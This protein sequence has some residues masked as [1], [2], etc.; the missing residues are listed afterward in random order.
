MSESLSNC[1]CACAAAVRTRS[2][3]SD[4]VFDGDLLRFDDVIGAPMSVISNGHDQNS[5]YVTTSTGALTDS[6]TMI[7]FVPKVCA[8][9]RTGSNTQLQ[10]LVVR[11]HGRTPSRT[12]RRDAVVLPVPVAAPSF[13]V[14]ALSFTAS[15]L[16]MDLCYSAPL[17][18]Q[19]Q[20]F[21]RVCDSRCV[22]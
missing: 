22:L 10:L 5:L 11:A 9:P 15:G 7:Y 14:S 16:M 4:V 3:R 20:S 8:L 6:E 2:R 17:T 1:W 18:L 12:R 21:S 19:S 13:S